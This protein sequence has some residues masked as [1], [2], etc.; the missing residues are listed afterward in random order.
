MKKM[1]IIIG[2]MVLAVVVAG[3]TQGT[4]AGEATK[5]TGTRTGE[6]QR[7]CPKGCGPVFLSANDI[8]T[9]YGNNDFRTEKD[10]NTIASDINI[11]TNQA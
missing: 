2:L 4:L 6:L 5:I 7:A 3:C 8:F 10:G 11:Y 9:N 1:W